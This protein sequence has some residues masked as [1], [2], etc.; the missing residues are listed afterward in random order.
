MVGVDVIEEVRKLERARSDIALDV[1]RCSMLAARTRDIIER[2]LNRP[3]E[4]PTAEQLNEMDMRV[5]MGHGPPPT[6]QSPRD[7]VKLAPELEGLSATVYA[8]LDGIP[9]P[10]PMEAVV[11][12][13]W[14]YLE[15]QDGFSGSVIFPI[16]PIR[17]QPLPG[18]PRRLIRIPI[19]AFAIENSKR[20]GGLSIE[21]Y[22]LIGGKSGRMVLALDL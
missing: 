16:H 8:P 3:L 19:P 4:T 21:P 1:L 11:L 13:F 14:K 2:A 20:R 10:P 22:G 6:I 18:I 17:L 9:K 7:L 12:S 15:M 5:D